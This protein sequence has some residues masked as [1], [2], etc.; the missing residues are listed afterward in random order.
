MTSRFRQSEP[1]SPYDVR[2]VLSAGSSGT[3]PLIHRDRDLAT[4][5]RQSED[6][7]PLLALVSLLL[8]A[9]RSVRRFL[10]AP[11]QRLLVRE[12]LSAFIKAFSNGRCETIAGNCP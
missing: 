2:L 7:S 5:R 6:R 11:G 3:A 8:G 1:P 9:Q 12:R 10:H 4:S